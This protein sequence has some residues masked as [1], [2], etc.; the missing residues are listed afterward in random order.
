MSL[1]LPPSARG[2]QPSGSLG[3]AVSLRC[4]IID[5]LNAVVLHSLSGCMFLSKLRAQNPPR[6]EA[7][8]GSWKGVWVRWWAGLNRPGQGRRRQAQALPYC[9]TEGCSQGVLGDVWH[10]ILATVEPPD[11]PGP[12]GVDAGAFA[13]TI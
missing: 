7:V 13:G 9:E 8:S 10:T 3:K 2:A 4:R 1:L 5:R 11:P 12:T 6:T